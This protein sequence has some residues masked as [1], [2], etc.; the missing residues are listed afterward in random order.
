MNLEELFADKNKLDEQYQFYIQKKLLKPIEKDHDLV[1]AHIEKAKH[2]LR[3]FD[4]NAKHDGYD[5][6]LIVT[7]YYT[8]YHL[9][10]A[11]ITQKE[12]SSKNHTAS[13]IFL[14]KHYIQFKED[15]RLLYELSIKKE[16]AELYTELK[17]ERHKASY[18]TQH[19]F[20]KK[21]I[22]EYREKVITFLHKTEELIE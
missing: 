21:K 14:I 22:T 4:N 10:L 6:W 20:S 19:N 3:F 2:N 1:G 17:E 13:L 9:V 5:D 16:D 11:L 12:F 8:L 7:L 18:D 15:I